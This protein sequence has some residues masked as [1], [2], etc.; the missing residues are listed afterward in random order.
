MDIEFDLV[1]EIWVNNTVAHLTSLS[2]E[3]LAAWLQR[4]LEGRIS[5]SF[6]MD[7]PR[8]PYEYV[9]RIADSDKSLQTRIRQTLDAQIPSLDEKMAAQSQDPR[10]QSE[11]WD[12]ISNM[13][14][15][16]GEIDCY[17]AVPTLLRW[18]DESPLNQV[19]ALCVQALRKLANKET[20]SYFQT[21]LGKPRCALVCYQILYVYE[22]EYAALALPLLLDTLNEVQLKMA[23]D[24]FFN[25]H[26]IV[27]NTRGEIFTPYGLRNFLLKNLS[28]ELAARIQGLLPASE[29]TV[30]ATMAWVQK[31][32]SN[33]KIQHVGEPPLEETLS[34][35]KII[36][37]IPDNLSSDDFILDL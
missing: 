36:K 32:Y 1:Q 20:V 23:F 4:V 30:H 17:R 21:Y 13:T 14:L 34:P 29:P 10:A 6:L 2:D 37:G 25:Y 35:Q 18:Y 33:F 22:M 24:G 26:L 28:P 19:R 5:E 31:C 11:N 27:E 3:A 12:F 7:T 9:T 8:D 16:C 15:L